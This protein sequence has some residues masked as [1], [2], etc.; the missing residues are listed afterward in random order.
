MET[1]EPISCPGL[2]SGYSIF[3]LTDPETGKIR[4]IIINK[5]GVQVGD[6]PTLE[7]AIEIAIKD[8]KPSEPEPEPEPEPS[9]S[10][11]PRM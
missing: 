1:K 11:V 4:F 2:P 5:N 10:S 3:K 9:P 6:S 8:N 7:G